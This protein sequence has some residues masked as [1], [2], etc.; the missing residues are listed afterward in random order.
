M[1]IKVGILTSVLETD[2]PDITKALHKLYSFYVNGYQYSTAYKKKRWDGKKSYFNKNGSFKTGLL[3]RIKKDLEKIEAVYTIEESKYDIPEL[4]YINNFDY[5]PYQQKAIEYILQNKR[6]IINSPTGCHAKGTKVLLYSGKFKNIEDIKINDILMGPDSTQRIVKKLFTGRETMYDIIPISG[7]KFRVNESH[8]LSLVK[9]KEYKNDKNTI[10]NISVKDY[11]QLSK[12]K[13]HLY[14]LYHSDT[15][16]FNNKENTLFD[17]YL[18]G[19]LIGDGSIINSVSLTTIDDEIVNYISEVSNKYKLKTR[20][21]KISYYLSGSSGKKNPITEELRK[22]K[23]FGCNSGN[24]FIPQ[25]YKTSSISNRL[26]LLAGL[27]DTDGYYSPNGEIDYITKSKVLADDIKFICQSLGFKVYL[28]EKI[29]KCKNSKNNH[30]E[31]YYRISING[32]L[33]IIPCKVTRKKPKPRKNIKN[34]LYTGFKIEKVGEE[35]YFGFELDKDHLY[36][37]DD[38]FVT[39]NSGKTLILAGLVKSLQPKKMVILFYEKGILNQTY[40]FLTEDCKLDNIGVNSGEGYIYGDVMLTTVQS[41]EKILDTHLYDAEVLMADEVHQLGNGDITVAAIQ[42]FPNAYYRIGFT[43]TL[44]SESDIHPRLTLEGAFGPEIKTR[45]TSELIEDGK[46]TKPI[47][48]IIRNEPIE[49]DLTYPEIYEDFIV[50]NVERNT[51]IKNIVDFI[52]KTKSGAKIL[53]LTKNLLHVSN[54]RNLIEDSYTIEGKDAISDRYN[55][56]SKFR[57]KYKSTVLIGTNVMQTGINIEEITHL[58][59]ARGLKGEIP[60]IQG[61]GRALR[62]SENKEVVYIYDFYDNVKYLEDHSKSR[63][64][65]YEEQGHEIEYL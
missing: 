12:W 17:P 41:I 61:L 50:N 62:V 9:T 10:L 40:K 57:D 65:H 60:T 7:E 33:D 45:T 8:I 34:H 64:N 26:M 25:E 5:Y 22:L 51:K 28:R 2:N 16:T 46:L 23:L 20:K 13:K 24:K 4:R 32:N 56:I 18:L 54:L 3:E 59:N 42:A 38:F 14:K 48:Q 30:S 43:G 49:S 11:L 52:R 36:I 21:S 1:N 35:D 19:L 53:I 44:Q 6:G 31:L 39:H 27:I 47:I 58:I 37:I 55:I 15:I 63:I 29:C